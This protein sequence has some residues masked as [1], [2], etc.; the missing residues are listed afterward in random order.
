MAPDKILPIP[1]M[2]Q[3][4]PV[5]DLLIDSCMII[6]GQLQP[7]VLRDALTELVNRWPILGSR[8]ARNKKVKFHLQ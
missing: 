5:Y 4:N 8:V 1:L 6:E 7:N 3:S 2:E